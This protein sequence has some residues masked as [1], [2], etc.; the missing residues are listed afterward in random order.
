M[1]K[2]DAL[3]VRVIDG[4]RVS[5]FSSTNAMH[6]QD[7][8]FTAIAFT[9]HG[10][11][12]SVSSMDAGVLCRP[13][14]VRSSSPDRFPLS[15]RPLSSPPMSLAALSH[16]SHPLLHDWLRSCERSRASVAQGRIEAFK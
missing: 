13:P 3:T 6:D 2:Q 14:D 5:K 10:A 11:G 8:S 12:S 1:A 4:R 7:D 16:R 9:S 15:P